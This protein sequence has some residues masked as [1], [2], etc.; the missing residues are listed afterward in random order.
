MNEKKIEKLLGI[1]NKGKISEKFM[2]GEIDEDTMYM[3]AKAVDTY[4]T[5]TGKTIDDWYRLKKN[6]SMYSPDR[7]QCK[8]YWINF[9][10][11]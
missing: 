4:K 2:N 1:R 5:K 9:V 3:Y 10:K 6:C 11:N 7:S 8:S